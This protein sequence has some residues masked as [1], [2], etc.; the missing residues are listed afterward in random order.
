MASTDDE[1]ELKK[2]STLEVNRI[3]FNFNW[4]WS[5]SEESG[6]TS[7]MV[8]HRKERIGA[9]AGI[10]SI[11]TWMLGIR[12]QRRQRMHTG[13]YD[14]W[15]ESAANLIRGASSTHLGKRGMTFKCSH[16]SALKTMSGYKHCGRMYILGR[17][18]SR[19][20]SAV[21]H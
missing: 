19:I 7:R 9:Q 1:E 20:E 21:N 6:E 12:K 10:G 18:T 3:K 2:G 8:R 5:L 15:C 4:K 17:K 13:R 11:T 16:P 14:P